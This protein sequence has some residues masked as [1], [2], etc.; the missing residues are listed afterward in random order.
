MS[1]RVILALAITAL[2]AV[3]AA[4]LNAVGDLPRVAWTIMS[5]AGFCAFYLIG[6]YSGRGSRG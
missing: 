6:W 3:T 2:I 4:A 1:R 5:V